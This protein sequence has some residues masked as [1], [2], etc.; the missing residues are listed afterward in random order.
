MNT[1]VRIPRW[2]PGGEH[3]QKRSLAARRSTSS[4][5]SVGNSIGDN[6][7][8]NVG[9]SIGDSVGDTI[10]NSIGADSEAGSNDDTGDAVRLAAGIDARG[11]SPEPTFLG[12]APRRRRRR[13]SLSAVGGEDISF[14]RAAHT[15]GVCGTA[16]ACAS[17]N[18][19]GLGCLPSV[20]HG[21]A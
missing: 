9:D 20:A 21:G 6:I 10:G 15:C 8:D 4:A 13:R 19:T 14:F 7:G 3:K 12:P 11:S 1:Q 16:A 18:A 5:A 17:Y 2:I